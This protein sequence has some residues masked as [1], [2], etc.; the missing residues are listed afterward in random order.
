[1]TFHVRWSVPARRDL[2]ALPGPVQLRVVRKVQAIREDPL[3][4]VRRL[5]AS[6]AWRLRVGDYRVLMDIDLGGRELRVLAVG[7]RRNVYD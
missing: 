3:R 2:A 5:T 1:M 7:H 4:Y 6:Q